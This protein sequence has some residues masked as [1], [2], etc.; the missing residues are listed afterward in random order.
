MR[1]KNSIL[2]RIVGMNRVHAMRVQ[3]AFIMAF[4]KVL[5]DV[6]DARNCMFWVTLDDNF[7]APWNS[8]IQ[9]LRF[10][11]GRTLKPI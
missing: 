1:P 8:T 6:E 7:R 3:V 9:R 4:R 2:H 11:E 10:S 5:L